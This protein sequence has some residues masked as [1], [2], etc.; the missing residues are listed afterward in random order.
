MHWPS[1]LTDEA[2]GEMTVGMT[3]SQGSGRCKTPWGADARRRRTSTGRVV[4]WLSALVSTGVANHFCR[5]LGN[6][7]SAR[8]EEH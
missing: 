7:T 6:F 5:K 3:C 1:R 8:E 4:S 2:L